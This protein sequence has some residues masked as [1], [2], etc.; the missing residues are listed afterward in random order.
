MCFCPGRGSNLGFICGV[1]KIYLGLL[2]SPSGLCNK[3]VGFFTPDGNHVAIS[4]K[5]NPP[6]VDLAPNAMFSICFTGI[7]VECEVHEQRPLARPPSVRNTQLHAERALLA[8]RHRHKHAR[9]CVRRRGTLHLH[10]GAGA[11]PRSAEEDPLVSSETSVKSDPR[12]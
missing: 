4:S 10:A 7:I 11:R 12:G 8:S 9:A 6:K 5:L 2:T 3:F 1:H